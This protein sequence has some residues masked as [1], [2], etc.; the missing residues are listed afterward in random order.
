MLACVGVNCCFY[1]LFS[2]ANV[3]LKRMFL[4]F[5][6]TTSGWHYSC[7]CSSILYPAGMDVVCVISVFSFLL[8]S[9]LLPC[10]FAAHILYVFVLLSHYILYK[11]L[12][13]SLF[14]LLFFRSFRSVCALFICATFFCSVR[15]S[16]IEAMQ[17]YFQS[18]LE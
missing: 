5:F 6:N 8:A 17:D 1:P 14:L 2:F 9:L 3:L 12:S 4:M 10:H 16:Y 18:D 11:L 7:A 15:L 13:F